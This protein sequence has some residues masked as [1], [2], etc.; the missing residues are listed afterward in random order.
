MVI[1]AD[2]ILLGYVVRAFG[3]KGGVVVKLLN[4]E[5]P[6][7]AEGLSLTICR[8]KSPKTSLTISSLLDRG[9]VFF[10][11]VNDR[12]E[13]E[14]LRG[15]EIWIKRELLPLPEDDEYYFADM[16][17]ASVV[18]LNGDLIGHVV[19]FSSN[20]AQILFEIKTIDGKLASI[21]SI[22]PIVQKID[23][24]NKVIV[25]DLPAGLLDLEP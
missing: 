8:P 25:V 17:G 24:D 10:E 18:D 16:L 9:R 20:N 7:L 21:P 15:A 12:D 1:M 11:G 23:S 14:A 5:S 22:K 3:V 2:E 13:A 4:E 6:T 19:D